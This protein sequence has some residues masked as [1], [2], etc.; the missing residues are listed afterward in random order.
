MY[1]KYAY[2][3]PQ[4]RI[5]LLLEIFD[6]LLG[7]LRRAIPLTDSIPTEAEEL[8]KP[9]RAAVAAL[10]L[11]VQAN[12]DEATANFARLYEFVGHCLAEGGAARIQDAIDVLQPL[13]EG[14]QQAR[15]QALELERSGQIPPL[16]QPRVTVT[17]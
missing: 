14:F 8:L 16:D 3:Q 9:C 2:P 10:A 1:G 6:R 7:R 12:E 15:E 5:D 13:Q 17:A 4:A 11:G